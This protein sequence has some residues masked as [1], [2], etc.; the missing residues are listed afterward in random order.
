MV[1]ALNRSVKMK[2]IAAFPREL[3]KLALLGIHPTV[4]HAAAIVLAK[5]RDLAKKDCARQPI[6]LRLLKIQH[7]RYDKRDITVRRFENLR[8]LLPQ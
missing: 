8:Y 6:E 2:A 3:P 4:L 1:V 7:G 5:K